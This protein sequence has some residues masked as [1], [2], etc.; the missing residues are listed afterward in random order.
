MCVVT[1]DWE[2]NDAGEKVRRFR[3]KKSLVWAVIEVT[4]SCNLNCIWCY[5]NSG[6]KAKIRREHMGLAELKKLV[7]MLKDSG[8][9]QITYSGGEPT[10]YPR[11]REAVKIA[12]DNDFVVHM[13]TNGFVLTRGFARELK[14]LGLS[15][16][17]TNIDSVD[18]KK[19]DY[20]RGR[21]GSFYRA[22]S[23]LKNAR[24]IGITCVSQT[25]LTKENETETVGIFELARSLGLQRC[26]VWDMM[27]SSGC[28]L[29]NFDIRPTNYIES[30]RKLT[31]FAE[32]T[33][34][35]HIESGEPF[36][37]LDF[38][39]SLRVSHIPCVASHGV[40]VNFAY[41]GDVYYCVTQRKP[42]FNVFSD[43]EGGFEEFYMVKLREF[44]KKAKLNPGCT[45][46][47]LFDKCGGGCYT[48]RSYSSER[49]DYWCPRVLNRQPQGASP[50]VSHSPA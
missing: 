35:K 22:V 13:N 27:P 16:I 43:V 42:M 12:K 20:L 40:L 34:G 23:A 2:E 37:P 29:E 48:R 36:F 31:K 1:F 5:A 49:T 25:V 26:R 24:K 7:G 15:Q 46:C 10:V 39:T 4:N 21:E 17:Q 38:E 19:H 9:N 32:G 45:E 50:D 6:N 41:N 30:L 33:G 8:L 14:S 47:E 18:P 11:I 3:K 44:L 28:A